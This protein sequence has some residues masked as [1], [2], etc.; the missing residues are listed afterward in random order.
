MSIVTKIIFFLIFAVVIFGRS[1]FSS[2]VLY[3]SLYGFMGVLLVLLWFMLYWVS[4]KKAVKILGKEPDYDVFA[5]KIPL[6]VTSDLDR[7]RVC[8]VDG[9][10]VL[11]Q[12]KKR[13]FEIVWEIPVKDIDSIG[14]GKVG[15]SY[16]YGFIIHNKDDKTEFTCSKMKKEKDTLFK[17]IGW[18]K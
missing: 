14:F 18:K 8:V 12:K 11:I 6:E 17:A 9:K 2:A 15:G 4:H 1:Y 13:K 7:G 16:R 10:I 3:W 5:G